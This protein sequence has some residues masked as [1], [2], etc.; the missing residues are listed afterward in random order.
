MFM[1]LRRVLMSEIGVLLCFLVI[2]LFMVIGRGVM[3]L[4]C[5]LVMFGCL[6]VCFVCHKDP[7]FPGYGVPPIAIAIEEMP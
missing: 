6:A 2:A 1:S 4:G 3:G 5:V 7:R